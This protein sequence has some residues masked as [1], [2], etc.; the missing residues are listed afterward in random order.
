MMP[1]VLYGKAHGRKDTGSIA[2]TSRHQ[3]IIW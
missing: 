3:E 1:S 2:F